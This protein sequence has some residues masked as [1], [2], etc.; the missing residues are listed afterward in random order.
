MSSK[1]KHLKCVTVTGC[2]PKEKRK[3]NTPH[4]RNTEQSLTKLF[5]KKS[6]SNGLP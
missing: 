1:T 2:G 6:K 5:S 3:Q 4:N